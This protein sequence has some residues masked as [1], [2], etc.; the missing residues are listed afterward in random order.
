MKSS[1]RVLG[2]GLKGW[3]GRGALGLE[4]TAEGRAW[5]GLQPWVPQLWHPFLPSERRGYQ[6]PLLMPAPGWSWGAGKS[7]KR[8]PPSAPAG[9][10]PDQH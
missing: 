8:V 1:N 9:Q 3:D 10:S 6:D 2:R 4:Q 7:C 5:E